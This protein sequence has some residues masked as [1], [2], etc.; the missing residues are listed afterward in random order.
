MLHLYGRYMFTMK[1]MPMRHHPPLLRQR[2]QRN[3]TGQKYFRSD[4]R[5][6]RGA[7]CFGVQLFLKIIRVEDG[8]EPT[9]VK[10]VFVNVEQEKMARAKRAITLLRNKTNR[11]FLAP[12]FR[13]DNLPGICKL[14]ALHLER[15]TVSRSIKHH[16]F[17]VEFHRKLPI[18]T[19][20]RSLDVISVMRQHLAQPDGD[21]KSGV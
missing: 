8:L 19:R 5:V 2:R 16:T 21:R 3:F 11:A 15:R 20:F 6:T 7:F 14:M 17:A 10:F 13:Q 9:P 4:S 1:I 12:N 18:F